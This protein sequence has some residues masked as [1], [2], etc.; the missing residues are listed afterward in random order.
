MNIFR[1]AENVNLQTL[2]SYHIGNEYHHFLDS[3]NEGL[4]VKGTK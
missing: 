4:S 3:Y 1:S 2:I